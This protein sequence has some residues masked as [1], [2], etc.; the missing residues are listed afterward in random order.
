MIET[1]L[2]LFLR[3]LP[4]LLQG[5]LATLQI[6][7]LALAV[8]LCGG[9]LAGVLSCNKL[10]NPF[11][12]SLIKGFVWT[13]R[14]TPLFVQLLII[15][16]VVPEISSIPLSPFTA[17]VMALGINSLAYISELV[18]AGVNAIAEGQWEA[19]YVVGLSRWQ[20]VKGIIL[21]QALRICIP[22]LTNEMTSLIKESS[23]L[24]VIGITELTKASKDIVTRELN[25]LT[26]YLTAA[27]LYL[28]MTST[29]SLLIQLFQKKGNL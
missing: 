28:I 26:I 20:T 19:A 1:Q 4:F 21:P 7:L 9:I 17:G 15:Y 10:R 2:S 13:I 16:Y 8:G 23:I 6:A 12:S 22:G 14:G 5:A 3:S 11:I 29:I 27:L 24:M 18:R 25:P